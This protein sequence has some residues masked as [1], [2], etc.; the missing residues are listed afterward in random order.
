MISCK[1]AKEDIIALEGNSK[2]PSVKK[3]RIIY[4]MTVPQ[5][6]IQRSDLVHFLR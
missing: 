6:R 4:K 3:K 2:L 1:G 5:R